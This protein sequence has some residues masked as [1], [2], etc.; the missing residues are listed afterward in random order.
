MSTFN[1]AGFL[2]VSSGHLRECGEVYKARFGHKSCFHSFS[3]GDICSV[4]H[5]GGC[6][7]PLQAS[8]KAGYTLDSSIHNHRALAMDSFIL[9]D[10]LKWTTNL[11]LDIFDYE[12]SHAH[13]V[14]T[15]KF[16]SIRDPIRTHFVVCMADILTTVASNHIHILHNTT[17]CT[18]LTFT[19]L[20]ETRHNWYAGQCVPIPFIR[21]SL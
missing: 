13:S 5:L 4:G 11:I 15:R 21:Y 7:W 2:L 18:V 6:I 1:I 12:E 14:S 19:M 17:C 8:G 16:R 3:M 9:I 10:K 20:H